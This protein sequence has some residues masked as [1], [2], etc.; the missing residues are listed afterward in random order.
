MT[1]HAPSNTPACGSATSN[2]SCWRSCCVSRTA[3]YRDVQCASRVDDRGRFASARIAQ[4]V[5]VSATTVT[6]WRE[7]FSQVGLRELERAAGSWAHAVDRSGEGRGDRPLDVARDAGRGD[8]LELPV[9]GRALGFPR[10]RCSGSGQRGWRAI[11]ASCGGD[12]GHAASTGATLVSVATRPARDATATRPT[13]DSVAHDRRPGLYPG[14]GAN[15]KL[16]RAE[17]STLVGGTLLGLARAGIR[18]PGRLR[19]ATS[20]Q[21]RMCCVSGRMIFLLIAD[22]PA[23]APASIGACGSRTTP[24]ALTAA[25]SAVHPPGHE[26]ACHPTRYTW[27]GR[28]ARIEDKSCLSTPL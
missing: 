22:L 16:G 1:R 8:A 7:R 3:P 12:T 28:R 26:V 15:R 19:P 10:R 24:Q 2:G 17:R 11:I 6:R 27:H 13:D 18:A 20:G 25:R 21:R 14:V 4:E 5:H 9:D 23:P